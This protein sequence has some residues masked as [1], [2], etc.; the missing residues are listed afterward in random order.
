MNISQNV[1]QIISKYSYVTFL[2][3]SSILFDVGFSLSSDAKQSGL[4]T[5]LKVQQPQPTNTNILYS[6]KIRSNIIIFIIVHFLIN[7]SLFVS[8]LENLFFSRD[9]SRPIVS[10]KSVSFYLSFSSS[11]NLSFFFYFQIFED[12]LSPPSFMKFEIRN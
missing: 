4:S 3:D 12:A 10:Y 7:L 8:Q 9:T 11:L 6:A 1:T 5:F 2:S